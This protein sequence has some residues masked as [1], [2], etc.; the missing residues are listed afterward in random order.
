[1]AKPTQGLK[2][3]TWSAGRGA[4]LSNVA[5]VDW[6]ELADGVVH[7]R[8]Q[9]LDDQGKDEE[10]S[11]EGRDGPGRVAD[12]R[13]QAEGQESEHGQVEA[14]AD[15]RPQHARLRQCGGG[16]RAVKMAWP[17][18]KALKDSNSPT[19]KATRAEH[20]GLGGQDQGT[21][22]NGGQ[23]RPD[24]PRAVL[25]AHDEHTEHTDGELA[26]EQTGEAQA[27]WDRTSTGRRATTSASCSPR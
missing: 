21:V 26:E 11:H 23:G 13:R 6:E 19:T 7:G 8:G 16:R 15:D 4:P 5:D 10:Q 17:T 9:C 2:A 24:G 14:A 12:D 25:G 1:M 22:R 27:G 20:G 18:K 3:E